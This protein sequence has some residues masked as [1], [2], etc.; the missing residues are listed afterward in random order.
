M[1]TAA[2]T[3]ANVLEI[4]L[5]LNAATASA[6]GIGHPTAGTTLGTT[7]NG[8]PEDMGSPQTSPTQIGTSWTTGPGAPAQFLRRVSLPNTIGAGI[9]WTFPRGVLVPTS[10]S[11]CE[12]NLSATSVIDTWWVWDE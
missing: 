12:W 6:F 2:T 8:Q 1:V 4:G 7:A 3:R 9:I 10:N 11:L 5:T